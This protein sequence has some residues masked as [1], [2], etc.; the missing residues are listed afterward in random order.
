MI[1]NIFKYQ[2]MILVGIFVAL[3]GMLTYSCFYQLGRLMASQQPAMVNGQLSLNKPQPGTRIISG[4]PVGAD[5]ENL[6][7]V[8]VSIDNHPDARPTY[9]LGRAAIVYELPTEG[10]STRFLALY[11]PGKEE[12]NKA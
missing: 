12:I 1:K 10:G 6:W 11:T 8:A 5:E 7:P 2:L 9:G 4:E 3:A